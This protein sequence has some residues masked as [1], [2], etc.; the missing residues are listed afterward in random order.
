[1]RKRLVGVLSAAVLVGGCGAS[2]DYANSDRP[3]A[4]LNVAVN[5]TDDRI[6]VSPAHIGAGPVVV[7]VANE[8]DRSRDVTLTQPA[9]ASSACVEAD[10][11]TGPINPKGTARV[12][13]ELVEGECLVGV[14]D[15]HGPRP[16]RLTVGRERRSAQADLLQP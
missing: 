11:S 3:A 12:A 1:M 5:V 14:R 15:T 6:T 2:D 13:V 16:V 7:I 10:A 4:P 9:G 8:S